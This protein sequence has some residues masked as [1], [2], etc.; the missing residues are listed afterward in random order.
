M[1]NPLQEIISNKP[2]SQIRFSATTWK[3]HEPYFIFDQVVPLV[4]LWN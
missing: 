4:L 3:D 1:I 2:L